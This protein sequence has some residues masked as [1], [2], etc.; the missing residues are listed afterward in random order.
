MNQQQAVERALELG[1]PLELLKNENQQTKLDFL[2]RYALCESA[3]ESYIQGLISFQDYI[4]TCEAYGIE[5]D[6]YLK[7]LETNLTNLRL[8]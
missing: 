4:N 7:T 6:Q 2:N 5:I 3:K 8:L 1:I